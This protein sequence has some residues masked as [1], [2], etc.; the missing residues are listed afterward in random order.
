M[1]NLFY[2]ANLMIY[3]VDSAFITEIMCCFDVLIACLLCETLPI[4]N[5]TPVAIVC[6]DKRNVTCL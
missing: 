4:M 5:L 1:C 2:F 6:I 3:S